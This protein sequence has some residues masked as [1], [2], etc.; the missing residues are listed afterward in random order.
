MTGKIVD[1]DSG[2]RRVRKSVEACLYILEIC[3]EAW[4]VEEVLREEMEEE[5]SCDDESVSLVGLRVVAIDPL[6][7][8]VKIDFEDAS[9]REERRGERGREEMA[10]MKFVM[11]LLKRKCGERESEKR[12]CA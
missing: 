8:I 6:A 1:R 11:S 2:N 9:W 10:G 7:V 3:E 12:P 4:R 5:R